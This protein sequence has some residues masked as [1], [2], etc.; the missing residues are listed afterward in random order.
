MAFYASQ[1]R[2]VV[3]PSGQN[4]KLIIKLLMGEDILLLTVAIKR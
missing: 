4:K 2:G 3:Q 1:S